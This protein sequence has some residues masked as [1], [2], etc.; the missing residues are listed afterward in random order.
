MHLTF[1]Q[2]VFYPKNTLDKNDKYVTKCYILI[3]QFSFLLGDKL[4]IDFPDVTETSS[5][6]ILRL[7]ANLQVF[8]ASKPQDVSRCWLKS[9]SNTS[10]VLLNNYALPFS[11]RSVRDDA[12][13]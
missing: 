10:T 12:K 3:S 2:C 7:D 5:H 1:I 9:G 11:G 8:H 13:N 6:F 4:V